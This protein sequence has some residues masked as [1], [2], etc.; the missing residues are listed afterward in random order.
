[1]Y[2]GGDFGVLPVVLLKDT[3]FRFRATFDTFPTKTV[4]ISD[5]VAIR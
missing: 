1:M 2:F 4:E 5:P 3:V